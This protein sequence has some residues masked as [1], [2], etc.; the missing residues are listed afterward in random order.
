MLNKSD[1][2]GLKSDDSLLEEQYQEDLE[3]SLA[4]QRLNTQLDEFVFKD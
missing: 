1:E 3:E 4:Q 2:S